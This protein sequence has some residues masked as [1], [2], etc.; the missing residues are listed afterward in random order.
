M[1]NLTRHWTRQSISSNFNFILA[2][3]LV[4]LLQYRCF[5]FHPVV[6]A[7]RNR[8]KRVKL[9]C[10]PRYC[11]ISHWVSI[12]AERRT[13]SRAESEIR[14]WESWGKTFSFALGHIARSHLFYLENF[15][16]PIREEKE[17]AE[18]ERNSKLWR[19]SEAELAMEIHRNSAHKA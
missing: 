4:W 18:G 6:I 10:A 8:T 3:E 11:A 12:S 14:S 2:N 15:N 17:N 5:F 9:I 7:Q 1:S 19:H 16:L 13:S